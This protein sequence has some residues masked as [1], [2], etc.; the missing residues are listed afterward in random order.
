MRP[1]FGLAAPF[2]GHKLTVLALLNGTDKWRYHWYAQHYDRH[3]R[4]LRRKKL[5]LLE[6]GIGGYDDPNEGGGSLRMWKT[7]FS[8]SR[9]F[10]LDIADKSI[11]A[12]H[13]IRIVRGSQDDAALLIQLSTEAGGFDIV[14]DDGSHQNSHIVATFRILFPLLKNGG[15]YAIEDVQTSYWP[16]YGGDSINLSNPATAMGFFKSLTDSLNYQE[17]AE[18]PRE[19]CDV[20]QT[21]VSM[22]FYHNLIVIQKGRNCESCPTGSH[23]KQTSL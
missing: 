11:H 22:H 23:D 2:F 13:R 4:P 19:L 1:L 6:I 14:I 3:F 10:G 15:F 7:F 5:N 12:E 20:G 21:I 18:A 17:F 9:I 16:A 8:R